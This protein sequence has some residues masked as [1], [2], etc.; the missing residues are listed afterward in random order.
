MSRQEPTGWR[1]IIARVLGTTSHRSPHHDQARVEAWE[2]KIR[3]S[4]ERSETRHTKGYGE[5][6]ISTTIRTDHGQR[7]P[8]DE[9]LVRELTERIIAITNEPKYAEVVVGMDGPEDV[10]WAPSADCA[11]EK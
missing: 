6:F 7:N 1:R 4:R 5:W 3:A 9:A 8:A 2:E 10:W 11:T